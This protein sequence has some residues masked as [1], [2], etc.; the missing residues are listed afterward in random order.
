ME[1]N[2]ITTVVEII[3][4][5]VGLILIWIHADRII[6]ASG[7]KGIYLIT[8]ALIFTLILLPEIIKGTEIRGTEIKEMVWPFFKYVGILLIVTSLLD[9][10]S[11]QA[12]ELDIN[13]ICFWHFALFIV[14][15][16][17]PIMEHGRV[18]GDKAFEANTSHNHVIKQPENITNPSLLLLY[19]PYT[20]HSV[21]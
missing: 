6:E 10:L 13:I 17:T 16:I 19:A 3:A 18:P 8:I 20:P 7:F 5:I 2:K 21:Q 11:K 14:I 4:T 12:G 9:I 15:I 1:F